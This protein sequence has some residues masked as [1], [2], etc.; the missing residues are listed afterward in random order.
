MAFKLVVCVFPL[1]LALAG[2]CS[3]GACINQA[4]CPDGSWSSVGGSGSGSG[5][6][7]GTFSTFFASMMHRDRATSTQLSLAEELALGTTA[8]PT[9]YRQVPRIGNTALLI[10]GDDDGFFGNS[11]TFASR[12]TVVCG[13]TQA[14]VQA[15]IDHCAAQNGALASWNGAVNGNGGQGLW[16]LV[17]YN[18]THEV[19][20]DERT[21]LVWSDNL[22]ATNWCRASGSSGGGP[23]A[24]ADVANVCDNVTYQNQVTPESRCAE[25]A[26][27]N[28][29][30]IYDSMKGGMRFTATGTSPSISWR[31]PTSADYHVAE[32]NGIRFPLPNIN[33]DFWTATIWSFS[34]ADAF[35]FAGEYHTIVGTSRTNSASVR[36]VGR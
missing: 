10:P 11:V 5:S 22:G 3:R 19:W 8:L 13:T 36:C 35:Y 2:G 34:R 9:G 14:T 7:T 17:T 27:L 16:K 15:R 23:F 28:T 4:A 24:E 21:L 33:T 26:G 25:A 31:L 29:P 32:A 6:P 18:A 12:P 1:L 20:R 30:A